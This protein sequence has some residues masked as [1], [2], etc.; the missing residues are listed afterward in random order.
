MDLIYV[1]IDITSNAI[2]TKGI[3]HQDF[4]KSIVHLPQNLLLLNPSSKE[5]DYDVHTGFKII[6]GEK[7]VN[8]YFY[9]S[10]R[11]KKEIQNKWIDFSDPTMLKELSPLEISELLYFG[12]VGNSLHSPF[13]YKLQNNFV[14]FELDQST[15]IYYRFIEEFYRILAKKITTIIFDK[16][17]EKKSFFKRVSPVKELNLEHIR[18]MKS[19]LQEGVVFCFHQLTVRGK[20]YC[21]PIYM[22]EDAL[23]KTQTDAYQKEP[24]IAFLLYKSSQQTWEIVQESSEL[25]EYIRYA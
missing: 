6:R 3:T 25:K 2:S 11:T 9:H 14:F 23:W 15:R 13:F 18:G 10:Y 1:H 22:I 24:L 8:Q 7:N 4:A 19:L 5:G 20:D 12:H 17:N 21:I 16:I